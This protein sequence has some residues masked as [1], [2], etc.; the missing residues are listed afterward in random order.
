MSGADDTERELEAWLHE[1]ARPMPQHVLESTLVSVGRTSQVSPGGPF[2][3]GW[4]DRRL[5]AIGA[6]VALALVAITIGPSVLDRFGRSAP[7]GVG[8][9]SCA[10]AP[11]NLVGWWPGDGSVEDIVG[12]RDAELIGGASF[13]PGLVNRAFQLDG[14]GDFVDIADDPALDVGRR[15]FGVALWAW[16]DHTGGEQVLMEKW[17]QR[18][19]APALGWTLTKLDTNA[20]GFFTEDG[21]GGGAG[22]SSRPLD[23][24]ARSW[25]YLVARRSGGTVDVFMNGERIA[26]ASNSSPILDLTS[27]SSVKLGH[28][29]GPGDTPGAQDP[30]GYFFAGALDEVQFV[31]GRTMTEDEVRAN[32][33]AGEAGTCEP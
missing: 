33:R 13:A 22:A 26:T 8:S 5:V 23:L 30:N 17:V 12:G 7:G 4:L 21:L 32:F 2:G 24:P 9:P 29:G 31:V 6:T 14:D 16:F 15:D 10:I 19:G 28:R 1:R 11:P 25:L 20:I 3:I 27:D 18:F